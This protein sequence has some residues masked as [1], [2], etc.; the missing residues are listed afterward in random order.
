M[1]SAS[2]RSLGVI[3]LLA[4]A[5]GAGMARAPRVF[6]LDPALDVSQYAHTAWKIR[7]GFSKGIIT[8]I[9]Q[10]PD[11]Y[12]W[13]GT[14]FGL[15]RFD[16]VRNVPWQPPAGEHLPSSFIRNLLVARDGRLWIGTL[17]GLASW[18]DGKLTQYPELTG[19]AVSALL[20]DREGSVWVGTFGFPSGSLCAIRQG[21]VHCDGEDGGPGITV[22]GLYEDS[23]GNLWVGVKDGL[24]R[25]KP[26]PP[27]FYPLSGERDGIEALGGDTDG[28]LLVGWKGGIHRFVDR[29]TE[30]YP[31]T[32]PVPPFDAKRLLRD[33]N[34]GLW[35][36]TQTQGL[37]HVYQGRTDVF[38]LPDGLSGEQV[39]ALFEDQEGSIWVSTTSG[40]DRFRDFAVATFTVSQGLSKALVVS[41]LAD[42]DGSVWL[43]T[44]GGLD[45]WRNGQIT[46]YDKRDGKLNGLVP[47]CLFQDSRGRIW[48]STDR[49]LGYLEN[50]QIISVNG[51]PGGPVHG[52]VDDAKGNLWIANQNQG[53]FQVANSRV[54][55]QIPWVRLGH[56]DPATA[57]AAD[58]LRGGLW[59]GFYRGGVAYFAEGQVRESYTTA[60]GLGDG[61]V[62]SLRSDHDG[63]LWAAT[64]GGLSRFKN[65]HFATLTSKNGLPCDPVHWV[66]QDDD[67]SFWLYTPCGL[68]RIARSEMDAWTAA[69]DKDK[70]TKRTVRFAVFDTSDG[71]RSLATAGGYSPQ[72]AKS[73]DGKLW[74]LPDDGVSVVDPRHLA[75]NKLPPRVHI[76]QITADRKTY[77]QNLYG[78]ASSSHPRLPPLARDMRIDYTAL[79]LAVPE[80]VRFRYEL[81][82]WDRDW[83]DAGTRRQA[84]YTN[85]PPR[86]YRFRVMAC[87]NSGVWN[88]AGTFLDFSIAP[89]YWQTNWFRVLCVLAFVSMLWTIYR[90]RVRVLEERQGILERHQAEIGALNERLM[91]AQEEERIRIAGEL[92]DGV[93]QQ[94]SSLSLQLGT[95]TILLPPDSEPKARVK[96][97]QKKLI[98]VGTGIRQ[99]SHELH[100][101]LLQ[102]AGLPAALSSYCEEFSKLRGIPIAYQA[103]ESVEE[104]SPGAALCIYRIAQE[105]LGNVAKHAQA[106]QVE[107]RL[108][109]SDSRVC[110]MVSDDGVGFNRD[111]IGKSGGL[112]LIN[113]RE[114]VAQLKGTFEFES[115]PGQGTTVKAEVP[116]RPAP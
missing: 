2:E 64:E 42:R 8:S 54:V 14:E 58:L 95:A 5:L 106:K 82:G 71:V 9:A 101:A 51:I 76:E 52:I 4:C 60:D 56:S 11:G 85:L 93:L 37:V 53:L 67:L 102:E 100:P 114:R 69:V 36:G 62:A 107:V 77:W 84:F 33:R 18:K 92:H 116:F 91:K 104:L 109:R 103:D 89:A 96:A 66:I 94:I 13:L 63:T 30:A 97:V 55:E 19:Q 75:F 98:E 41:A 28:A 44:L 48:F 113:M 65:G 29:K 79:S 61:S 10:T 27:K 57:L 115:K 81:E 17:E 83:Q 35:I 45:R 99:L 16:G 87:N 112:G 22:A 59:V 25:W 68:V 40:L 111:G 110:L 12:L 88:E 15:L 38:A 108:T 78:D 34:G 26:G 46:A 43:A 24:W 80:K 105:A 86:N 47:N 7:E 23:K 70:D 31:L 20:E 50:N 39:S 72:V 49:G 74:F 90:L 3:A 73:S 32:G 1:G 6:A 21:N